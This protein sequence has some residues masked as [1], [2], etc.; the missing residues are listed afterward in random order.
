MTIKRCMKAIL[1]NSFSV[2]FIC[3]LFYVKKSSD[4]LISKLYGSEHL[5]LHHIS[6]LSIIDPAV[7]F[8]FL[9]HF[10]FYTSSLLFWWFLSPSRSFARQ[11]HR[12]TS[13]TS[14]RRK[15]AIFFDHLSDI[16]HVS[17]DSLAFLLETDRARRMHH[18]PTYPLITC[19]T[20]FL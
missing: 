14:M 8:L 1:Q 10:F 9:T 5:C 3:R 11:D 16:F 17:F 12:Q 7:H 2:K 20:T 4:K 19:T 15:G 13:W 18:G 6:F